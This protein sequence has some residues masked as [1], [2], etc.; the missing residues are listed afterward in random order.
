MPARVE[1]GEGAHLLL[2]QRVEE[3]V[4][5]A[6]FEGDRHVAIDKREVLVRGAEHLDQVGVGVH[7]DRVVAVLRRLAG[8]SVKAA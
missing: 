3:L 5:V 8:S 2:L 1:A 4:E 6:T 7:P